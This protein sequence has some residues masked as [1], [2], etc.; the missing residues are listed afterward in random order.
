V[1]DLKARV[2]D[3]KARFFSSGGFWP[4]LR[5]RHVLLSRSYAEALCLLVEHSGAKNAHTA[6]YV[7]GPLM[8]LWRSPTSAASLAF[9]R[10]LKPGGALHSPKVSLPAKPGLRAEAEGGLPVVVPRPA[11]SRGA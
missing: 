11:S 2:V 8:S 7:S 9:E 10:Y 3:W 6:E 4:N 1:L 5:P